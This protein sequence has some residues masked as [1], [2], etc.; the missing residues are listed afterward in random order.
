MWTGL[1]TLSA[2]PGDSYQWFLD[3]NLLSGEINQTIDISNSGNGNYVCEVTKY[4]CT[5][6]TSIVVA[7]VGMNDLTQPNKQLQIFPNPA[8]E[9]IDIIWNLSEPI[10]RFKIIDMSGRVVLE[11]EVWVKEEKVRVFLERLSSGLYFI[12]LVANN[13]KLRS[14]FIKR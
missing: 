3:G 12:E 4:C 1:N 11:N 8:S 9:Y 13:E 5:Y 2:T 14:R 6:N 7:T 10:E